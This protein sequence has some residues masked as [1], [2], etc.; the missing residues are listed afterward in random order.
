M[1][2]ATFGTPTDDRPEAPDAVTLRDYAGV[3]PEVSV[4]F[5]RAWAEFTDPADLDQVFRCD[6]T[7]LTSRYR[8]IFGD[9]CPGIYAD[10]A[11]DG[12]CT[13]GAHFA[14]E[15]DERYEEQCACDVMRWFVSRRRRSPVHGRR[16]DVGSY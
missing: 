12:C 4:G 8:C 16:T 6:L 13:L 15:E 3:M 7:W 14:D 9:G 5:P 1:E 11:N 10:R 2:S